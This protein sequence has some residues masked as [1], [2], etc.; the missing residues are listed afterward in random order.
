MAKV[1]MKRV[2]AILSLLPLALWACATDEGGGG[3][4]TDILSAEVGADGSAEADVDDGYP[5]GPY[6]YVAGETVENLSFYDPASEETVSLARWYQHPT[7]KLLMLV[8]TAAW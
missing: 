6:G 8:S 7:I 5:A 1:V 4:T 2:L 3:D